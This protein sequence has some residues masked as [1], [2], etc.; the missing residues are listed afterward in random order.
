MCVYVCVSLFVSAYSSLNF[1]RLM[2]VCYLCTFTV[3]IKG[4]FFMK[5]EFKYVWN[6]S[7][8]FLKTMLFPE[9]CSI[10]I[11]WLNTKMKQV[12]DRVIYFLFFNFWNW[13]KNSRSTKLK[14]DIFTILSWEKLENIIKGASGINFSEKLRKFFLHSIL[15]DLSNIDDFALQKYI[16]FW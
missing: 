4:I 9:Q 10:G 6:L 15:H 12:Y 2:S 8:V 16:N 14:H 3:N 11:H 7:I 13:A 1:N 5:Y